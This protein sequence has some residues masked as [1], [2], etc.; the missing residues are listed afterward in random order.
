MKEKQDSSALYKIKLFLIFFLFLVLF[1]SLYLHRDI[2]QDATY[3]TSNKCRE[4]HISQYDSWRNNTLHPYIFLPISS[5][6]A[7]ILGDFDS[8]DPV[9]TFKKEEIEFV[10]GSRWEQVYAR[11]IDGEY[12]PFPAKWYVIEKRWVPYKVKDWHDTPMSYKC[13]GCHTTGFDPNTLEF[14]EF[15]VGCEACHGP[16]RL[17]VQH[18]SMRHKL[19]CNPCHTDETKVQKQGEKDHY[20]IRTVSPALCG[21][22]HNRGTTTPTGDII[23]GKQFN[24]PAGF[25]PGDDL[26]ITNF[27]PT[28]PKNDKKGNNWWGNGLSKNRHQEFSDLSRSAHA[29]SLIN[30]LENLDGE[31]KG[32]GEL[33]DDCLQ[34]HSTDYR[35][36]KEG[37]KPNLMTAR[38]GITCVA[39]HEPHGQHKKQAGFGDGTTLCRNCHMQKTGDNDEPHT[40][41]TKELV[42][43]TDCHMPKIVKTGGFFSLHSHAFQV[44]MPEASLGNNM[45]N[46]CQNGGCHADKSLEWAIES[47]KQFYGDEQRTGRAKR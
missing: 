20:I 19:I 9:V 35:H 24:F 25:Q 43:C 31:N 39:C 46:S 17:H 45:P 15:G 47:Y 8:G 21:Q 36:A 13:N 38:Y 34:C 37:E 27:I 6:D 10:I 3:I 44:V 12:Y 16:G 29:K 5:P 42:G 26:R 28:T 4:C 11:I 2:S 32:C 23:K 40:P 30:L 7:K 33:S 22:C 14:S 1:V 41:C 18:E